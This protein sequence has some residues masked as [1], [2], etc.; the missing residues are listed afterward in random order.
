KLSLCS[1]APALLVVGSLNHDSFVYVDS[2]PLRGQTVIAR[3]AAGGLGGKGANQAIAAR[4]LGAR[5][6]F[7]GAVGGDAVGAASRD[8]LIAEGVDTSMLQILES[9]A[10]GTA[11][12]TV[13]DSG[14]N[15]IVVHSGANALIDAAQV[16]RLLDGVID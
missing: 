7:V 4:R 9:A 11:A 5:V 16:G 12:I 1:D 8:A 10:T 2:L 15:T 14:E 6:S 3:S 13:E